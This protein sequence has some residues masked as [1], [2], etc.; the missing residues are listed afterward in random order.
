MEVIVYDLELHYKQYP[1]RYKLKVWGC[2]LYSS[3]GLIM[4][5]HV[6]SNDNMR[7][8]FKSKIR[9]LQR[10]SINRLAYEIVK[11]MIRNASKLN[12]KVL[13]LKNGTTVIDAGVNAT[14]G[15]KVAE[16]VVKISLGGLG[17]ARVTS[18]VLDRDFC[19]P[20]IMAYTDYPAVI[21][22]AM[23]VWIGIVNAP[24]VETGGYTA[25]VSGPGRAKAREPEKVFKKI[26]YNDPADVAVL[27]VQPR[28]KELPPVKF[29][30]FLAKKCK[31]N[32]ENLYLV[33]TPTYSITGSVQVSARSLED[34]F[35]RL[36][37]YY[38]IPYHRIENVMTMTAVAPISPDVFKKPCAWADDMIRYGSSVHAWIYSEEGEDLQRIVKETVIESYPEVYGKSF[39]DIAVLEKKYIYPSLDLEKIAETGRGFIV[40]QATI[41]D[42]RTGLAYRAGRIHV[43][44]L[45]RLLR[46]PW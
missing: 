24:H 11:D 16:L 17:E 13:E 21:G 19:L 1:R 28:G 23:Y 9:R 20:A 26:D 33:V 7:S 4:N 6:G 32:P 14:G 34:W 8:H 35:W 5:Y 2:T 42:T 22:L 10:I 3:G 12:L 46:K 38:K 25:W 37:E 45:K 39:Y 31:V 41:Y 44:I 27:I 18:M 36:T 15:Y 43:D 40:A 30:N 29:A